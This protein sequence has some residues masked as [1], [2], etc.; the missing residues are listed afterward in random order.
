[1]KTKENLIIFSGIFV[2][3]FAV[4]FIAYS[5]GKR[6][7]LSKQTKIELKSSEK[8]VKNYK[9]M[10]DSL[11]NEY[12]ILEKQKQTVKTVYLKGK[13]DVKYITQ[14]RIK[15]YE[16]TLC[17]KDVITLKDQLSIS[18][19]LISIQERQLIDVLTQK[20]LKEQIIEEKDNQINLYKNKKSKIK[21][22]GIGIIGGA[23]TDFEN[24][25]KPFLG[26]GVS[27]NFIRF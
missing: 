22:F 23:G 13:E 27:Y 21:P 16:D 24:G 2:L 19:S 9:K 12:L 17:K 26:L 10:Y 5:S 1:M 6:S 4:G 8:V 18:D 15:A 3:L 14:E 20:E 7:Q 11:Q 25:L